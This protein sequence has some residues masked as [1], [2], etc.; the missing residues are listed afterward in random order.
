MASGQFHNAPCTKLVIIATAGI[1]VLN[2]VLK[3]PPRLLTIFDILDRPSRIVRLFVQPWTYYSAGEL[4][5]GTILLYLFRV[6]ERHWG[7]PKFTGYAF[8]SCMS[9]ILVHFALFI[10]FKP[11]PFAQ[12]RP[13]PY[14]LIFS[15]L[16]RYA[17]E[18]PPISK[19]TIFG[20]SMTDKIFIY[21]LALQLLLSSPPSSTAAGISGLLGGMLASSQLL[22]LEK[23]RFPTFLQKLCH[24]YIRPLLQSSSRAY[25]VTPVLNA[26]VA[27]MHAQEGQPTSL[28]G[29]SSPNAAGLNALRAARQQAQAQHPRA[30]ARPQPEQP[31]ATPSVQ[32]AAQMAFRVSDENVARLIELGF[33]QDSARAALLANHNNVEMAATWLFGSN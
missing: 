23:F 4:L 17:I 7:T 2:G 27:S 3:S 33:D 22:R 6:F 21:A 26:S 13:G 10:V 30:V 25:T 14:G 28:L 1:S 31:A 18:I 5:F 11:L 29:P 15:L 16:W 19:F 32:Y 20:I 8:I 12:L 9:S 24:N